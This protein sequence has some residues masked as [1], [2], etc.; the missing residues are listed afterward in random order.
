MLSQQPSTVFRTP[1][2]A[3]QA[4]EIA[5]RIKNNE[6]TKEDLFEHVQLCYLSNNP[7][8]G[9]ALGVQILKDKLVDPEWS[10]DDFLGMNKILLNPPSVLLNDENNKEQTNK[11]L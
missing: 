4:E 3:K 9:L 8:N 2:A 7:E 11:I 6:A 5:T 10:V 1:A